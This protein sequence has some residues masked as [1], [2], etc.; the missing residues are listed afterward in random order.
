[1]T[2]VAHYIDLLTGAWK[3]EYFELQLARAVARAQRLRDPLSLV[4]VDVDQLQEHNDVHGATQLDDS[5]GWLA[6]KIAEVVDGRGPIGRSGGGSFGT[7]LPTFT[8]DRALRLAQRLRRTVA[9]T[10][11]ASPF[12]DYHLTVSVGVATLRRGEPW[13]N[14]IEAAERACL[15]AKQGGR[16]TVVSR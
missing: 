1:M 15:K 4:L 2:D 13:G 9:A 3:K 5:I 16:D 8:E 11:H 10:P 12:G 14:L 6:T 7:Y